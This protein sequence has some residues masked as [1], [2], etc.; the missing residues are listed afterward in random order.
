MTL[1]RELGAAISAAVLFFTLFAGTVAYIAG[2]H[3][4]RECPSPHGCCTTRDCE[5]KKD[6]CPAPGPDAKPAP[7]PKTPVVPQ[8]VPKKKQG[9]LGELPPEI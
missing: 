6:C 5:P 9:Q 4:G 8:P 1:T 7:L 2:Q 3:H